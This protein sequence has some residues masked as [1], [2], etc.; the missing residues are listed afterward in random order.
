MKTWR[1]L[2]PHDDDGLEK[3]F[4]P[5]QTEVVSYLPPGDKISMKRIMTA[6]VIL[7]DAMSELYG[8]HMNSLS[9][10][11]TYMQVNFSK[12]FLKTASKQQEVLRAAEQ[13]G[14]LLR[15]ANLRK[16]FVNIDSIDT[17]I[18]LPFIE[19]VRAAF[20]D[21]MT[22]ANISSD[23]TTGY[24]TKNVREKVYEYT[25]GV[26]RYFDQIGEYNPEVLT[27]HR[28]NLKGGYFTMFTLP[29][30]PTDEMYR[31]IK[32]IASDIDSDVRN[33]LE[34]LILSFQD[35]H[36]YVKY[37]YTASANKKKEDLLYQLGYSN[38]T[39]IDKNLHLSPNET[40]YVKY[41]VN[42]K[43]KKCQ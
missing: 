36:G 33:D 31:E 41:L 35:F 21:Q 7:F 4:R 11:A 2:D 13:L 39:D 6:Y 8:E 38:F 30:N 34:G 20:K 22:T 3:Y 28:D 24:W 17:G 1:H 32:E 23:S 43:R 19:L 40:K 15:D 5:I 10:I 14:E 26:F 25:K 9:K 18:I 12:K 42:E 27:N 16:Y 29:N 37:L